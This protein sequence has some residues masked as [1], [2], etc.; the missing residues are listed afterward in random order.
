MRSCLIRDMHLTLQRD[1]VSFLSGWL[2]KKTSNQAPM[3]AGTESKDKNI[4][5]YNEFGDQSMQ[6]VHQ[7]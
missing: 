1:T 6:H 2:N 4:N 5:G 7:C 3:L